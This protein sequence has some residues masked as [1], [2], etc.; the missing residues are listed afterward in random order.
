MLIIAHRGVT[1]DALENS[2]SSFHQ[3]VHKGCH[4]IELDVMLTKDHVPIVMHDYTLNRTCMSTGSVSKLSYSQIKEV[5]LKNGEPIPLFSEVVEKLTPKIEINAELKGSSSKIAEVVGKVIS[6]SPFK[7][8]II[9]SSF[10]ETPLLYFKNHFPNVKRAV[11][12]GYDTLRAHPLYFFNPNWFLRNCGTNIFHPEADLLS[13]T[14]LNRINIKDLVIYPWVPM[15]GEDT[16]DPY[17]LWEKMLK[18][19]I[20]GLCTNKPTQLKKFLS[21][22]GKHYE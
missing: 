3:A 4:R 1:E 2:W 16:N 12:W 14:L 11:L 22:K 19:K 6:N 5:R 7:D 9:V 8:R 18:L 20:D 15:Q 13:S 21:G 10:S 17:K